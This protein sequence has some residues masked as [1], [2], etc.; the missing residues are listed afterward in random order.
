MP[1]N[2]DNPRVETWPNPK[3][4]HNPN[5]V[6]RKG[7]AERLDWDATRLQPGLVQVNYGVVPKLDAN[8]NPIA[9]TMP[10]P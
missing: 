3:L 8:G 6:A 10:T 5:E 4:G 9:P 2:N 1:L 7:D